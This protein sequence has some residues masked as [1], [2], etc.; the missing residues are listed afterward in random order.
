VRAEC[1][2]R[3]GE[4][5]GAAVENVGGGGDREVDRGARNTGSLDGAPSDLEDELWSGPRAVPRLDRP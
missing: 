1:L 4:A 3:V 5:E 2:E